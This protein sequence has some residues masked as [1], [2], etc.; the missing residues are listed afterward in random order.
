MISIIT[1][2]YNGRQFIESCIKVVI[3]QD[4]P[5]VEHIIV[6][7]GSVD[8]TVDLVQHYAE[9]YAHIRWVSEKD[10]GQSDAMNKGIAMARGEILGFLNVDDFY[11]PGVLKRVAELFETLPEPGLLVGNCNVWDNHG[12]L[13]FVNKPKRLKFTKLLLGPAVNP[14]PYNSSAYFYHAS[15]HRRIGLYAVNE[16]YAMDL[17]F[18][19]RAVQFAT[20]K[21]LDETWGNFRLMEGTKTYTDQ[22]GINQR[23]ERIL[24]RYWCDL[25]WLLRWQLAVER[26]FY[27][28]KSKLKCMVG[29]GKRCLARLYQRFCQAYG[30]FA[31]KVL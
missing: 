25:P 22:A 6:D 23:V 28:G 5:E 8:G 31:L 18:L 24:R 29:E 15:L 27:S 14:F 17:D 30:G 11:E 13:R 12:E 10:N 21:Y 4:Y 19:L 16:H 2:V 26:R 7:G 9:S 20:V 1:P 3:D